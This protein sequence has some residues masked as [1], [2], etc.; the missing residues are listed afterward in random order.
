MKHHYVPQFFLKRWSNA[1]G[2]VHVF[3]IRNGVIVSSTR[4]PEYTGFE[5]DL[6]G[7]VANTL[8]FGLDHIEKRLFGPIDSNA[9]VVLDKLERHEVISEDEHIA[10][11]F[12]LSSL[13]IR[14]PDVLAFL[15]KDGIAR[16]KAAL[17][18]RDASTLPPGAASTK[19]WFNFN[20][21]GAIE[22]MT[23]THWL[24]RI[25]L[26]DGVTAAFGDL[27]WWIR[28][29]DP[30]EAGLLLSDLP[31]HWEG[32]FNS[33]R[34]MIQLPIGPHRVF[35]GARSQDTEKILDAIPP[36][37]LVRRINRTTLASSADRIWASDE[38]GGHAV[39]AANLDVV[40]T[41]A[42]DFASLAPAAG[43]RGE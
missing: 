31:I 19:T 30:D 5:H 26:H 20:Y 38:A 34:F 28:E 11:T 8:G 29:F 40:G 6:Y 21:P 4:T 17:V 22:A 3:S 14:Q 9:A 2:K 33:D 35:F 7:L 15:R 13:R 25:I 42:I 32:G 37:D 43:P 16:M 23:L 41:N 10:W 12:F 18:E 24:P 39:I 27:R 36:P 1:A